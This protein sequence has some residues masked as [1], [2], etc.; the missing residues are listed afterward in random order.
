[1]KTLLIVLCT[2]CQPFVPDETISL[3]EVIVGFVIIIL[4]YVVGHLSSKLDKE[5]K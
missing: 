2:D 1:M 5:N 4:I 3:S